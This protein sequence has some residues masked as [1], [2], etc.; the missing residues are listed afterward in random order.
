MGRTVMIC[1]GIGG[2]EL[3]VPNP[4]GGAGFRLW[5]DPI[6][7]IGGGWILLGLSADGITP[8]VPFVGPLLPGGPLLDY[9][10]MMATYLADQGWYVIAP[11]YD[12]RRP[13]LV[14]AEAVVESIRNSQSDGPVNIIAHSRGGLVVRDALGILAA[15]GELSLVGRCAGLGVPHQGSFYGPGMCG[16]W[17]STVRL[18]RWVMQFPLDVKLGIIPHPEFAQVI[19]SWPS[20][21]ELF[22]RPDAPGLR[23]QVRDLLY[24]PSSWSDVWAPVSARW[25]EAARVSWGTTPDVPTGVEWIDVYGV[26]AVTPVDLNDLTKPQFSESYEY[27]TAGDGVVPAAWALQPGRYR[28]QTPTGHGALIYDPRVLAA[29]HR[30]LTSGLAG[31]LVITGQL[32]E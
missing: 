2:S 13:T 17:A 27:S 15:A 26:G 24:N 18:L 5:L 4:F 21:Y 6:R 28:I 25:L 8:S 9:Y 3:F 1:P 29:L 14:S 32:V 23:P 31:D 12:F 16:G 11:H 22:P 30:Y 20:I 19:C 7:L 10:G